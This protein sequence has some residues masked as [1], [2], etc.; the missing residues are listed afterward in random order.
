[1]DGKKLYAVKGGKLQ[2]INKDDVILSKVEEQIIREGG[3]LTRIPVSD[4]G[5][6][7]GSFKV[8]EI[9]HQI[10]AP[11]LQSQGSREIEPEVNIDDENQQVDQNLNVNEPDI[12]STN[13]LEADVHN[14]EQNNS[15]SEDMDVHSINNIESSQPLLFED[16]D[17]FQIFHFL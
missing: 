14:E 15:D 2:C 1:M 5:D 17:H 11:Q 3:S 8:R 6:N 13:D 4:S 12:P 16:S 7:S 10:S 9:P